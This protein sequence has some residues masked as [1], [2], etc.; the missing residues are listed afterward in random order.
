MGMSFK[1]ILPSTETLTLLMMHPLRVQVSNFVLL[2]SYIVIFIG[3]YHKVIGKSFTSVY[4]FCLSRLTPK[5]QENN[6]Q[7]VYGPQAKTSERR[8]Q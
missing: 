1:D 5:S 8:F 3:K 7:G 4:F 2:F 6:N